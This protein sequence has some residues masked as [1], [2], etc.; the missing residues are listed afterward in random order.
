[1]LLQSKG[2][3]AVAIHHRVDLL[4]VGVDTQMHVEV[5]ICRAQ[6]DLAYVF[7]S[8][9]LPRL[10]TVVHC[11]DMIAEGGCALNR[12]FFPRL[13]VFLGFFHYGHAWE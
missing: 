11:S 2:W 8:Q 13:F 12:C 7:H 1:M 9:A 4:R 3:T 10:A 5:Y 6:I